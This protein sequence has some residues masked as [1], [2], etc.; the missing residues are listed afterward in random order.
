M[1]ATIVT[2]FPD[3]DTPLSGR[4]SLVRTPNGHSLV[5]HVNEKQSGTSGITLHMTPSHVEQLI[6][7]LNAALAE[8]DS[9]DVASMEHYT[10]KLLVETRA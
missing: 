2:F 10:S 9:V 6:V 7:L 1:S 5:I 8:A 3:D 4:V